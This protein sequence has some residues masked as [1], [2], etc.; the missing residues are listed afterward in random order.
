MAGDRLDFGLPDLSGTL[1]QSTDA[2]FQGKV[3]LV[4]LWGMFCP[5][6]LT[7]IPTFI[8]LQ[9]RYRDAGLVM[10]GIAFERIEDTEKRRARLL[11][12][13]D[14]RGINYLVLD[15][16]SLSEFEAALPAMRDVAGFP[17]EVLIDRRGTVVEARNSYGYKK[18]WA[19]KLEERL[20]GL[21]EA[22]SA[23]D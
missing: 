9:E 17:V 19:R 4:D 5:P 21:L 20:V 1:V 16:G 2:R 7:E 3:V 8:D 10:V 12:F 22:G 18:R 14:E 15:G 6:C 13:V 23:A 11:D